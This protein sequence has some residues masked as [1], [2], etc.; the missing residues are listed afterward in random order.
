MRK[1]TNAFLAAL[2]SLIG[3]TL[4]WIALD[5]MLVIA[6]PLAVVELIGMVGIIV[7]MQ[8]KKENE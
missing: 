8:S 5:K 6:I 4:I 1:S 3:L 7:R 2:L